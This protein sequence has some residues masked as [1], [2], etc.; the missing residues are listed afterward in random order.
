MFFI[1]LS[2]FY[3]L[4]M[5]SSSSSRLQGRYGRYGSGDGGAGS[6]RAYLTLWQRRYVYCRAGLARGAERRNDLL[7]T[8][9]P[10]RPL[11]SLLCP[12]PA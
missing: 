4:V 1:I 6:G 11:S 2:T 9:S 10:D 3:T 5:V 8:W 7:K 12:V